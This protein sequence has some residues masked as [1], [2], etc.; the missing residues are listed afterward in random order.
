MLKK[1]NIV[2]FTP[3]TSNQGEKEEVKNQMPQHHIE[4]ETVICST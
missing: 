1:K 4:E 3:D 2:W